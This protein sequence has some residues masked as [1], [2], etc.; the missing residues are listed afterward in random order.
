M[1]GLS[2]V[3]LANLSDVSNGFDGH[4]DDGTENDYDE[5]TTGGDTQYDRGPSSTS[6]NSVIWQHLD[7]LLVSFTNTFNSLTCGIPI[8]TSDTDPNQKARNQKD[9]GHEEVDIGDDSLDEEGIF[10]GDEIDPEERQ[11][12][13]DGRKDMDNSF[14]HGLLK[15]QFSSSSSCSN[16]SLDSSQLF[17][18]L[19]SES[20]SE[21]E[22]QIRSSIRESMEKIVSKSKPK[23][24]VEETIDRTWLSYESR[25]DDDGPDVL[26]SPSRKTTARAQTAINPKS[27]KRSLFNRGKNRQ[28]I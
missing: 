26:H 5:S 12:R 25:Q 6:K 2:C 17:R 20:L 19:H 15:E 14:D 11:E 9:K 22:I 16:S 3:S 7:P 28:K 1:D 24:G 8:T 18:D 13:G 27:K 21:G 23:H 4:D 10:S